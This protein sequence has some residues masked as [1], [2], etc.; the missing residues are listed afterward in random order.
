MEIYLHLYMG[1]SKPYVYTVTVEII[2]AVL[3]STFFLFIHFLNELVYECL[4]HETKRD[5]VI[6]CK[7][8][9]PLVSHALLPPFSCP[10]TDSL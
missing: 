4:S 10:F 9:H 1:R 6:N 8:H 3:K 5:E 7:T 2:S